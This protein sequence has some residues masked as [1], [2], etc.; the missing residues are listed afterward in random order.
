MKAKPSKGTKTRVAIVGAGQA[1]LQL[2]MSLLDEQDVDVTLYSDRPATDVA[3]G[4][5]LATAI[6]FQNKRQIERELGLDF[7]SGDGKQVPGIEIEVRDESSNLALSFDAPFKDG[8]GMALDFRLKFPA[9]MDEYEKRG[10]KLIIQPT[11]LDD[12]ENLTATHDLVVIATGK[13][14]LSRLFKRNPDRSPP[15]TKP[16]RHIAAAVVDRDLALSNMAITIIPGGAEVVLLPIL[17][18]TGRRSTAILVFSQE[19]SSLMQQYA[20]IETGE[21]VLRMTLGCA[22][23]YCPKFATALHGAKLA[24]ERSHLRGAFT[25]VVR[26]PVGRLPSGRIVMGTADCLTL[27]DPICGNGLNNAAVMTKVLAQGIKENRD[28][29]FNESWMNAIFD[30]FW[31]YGKSVYVFMRTL[32]EQPSYFA[33]ALEPA[34]RSALLAS[35]IING[36]PDPAGFASWMKDEE[37]ARAHVRKHARKL[38]NAA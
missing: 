33:E 13:G 16:M 35:D 24:D 36:Y 10:G 5:L 20:Q 15:Y 2:G 8:P 11:D 1:G 7:W 22:Q 9:W 30:R 14:G 3:N 38:E 23:R 31:E 18:V 29:V 27:V 19:G 17:A 37:S 21:D 12:L 34:S 32:L 26:D 4:P 28:G 25:P 6:M